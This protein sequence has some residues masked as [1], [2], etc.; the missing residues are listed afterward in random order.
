PPRHVRAVIAIHAVGADDDVLQDL[1]ERRA[2]MD[3]PVGV[4]RPVMQDPDRPV[5]GPPQLLEALVQLP[6]FPAPQELRFPLAQLG[7]HGELGARQ[8]QRLLVVHVLVRVHTTTP[9]EHVRRS[10]PAVTT[11]VKKRPAPRRDGQ[12]SRGTTLIER[13][14]PRGLASHSCADNGGSRPSLLALRLSMGSSGVIFSGRR[15]AGLPPTPARLG[16]RPRLLSPSSPVGAC[17]S[18]GPNA[19]Q[20]S[21]GS[22]APAASPATAASAGIAGSLSRPGAA[23]RCA[24]M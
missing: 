4:G 22:P 17:C 9:P 7:A 5:L 1:V 14:A 20:L 24:M 8:L 12:S 19:R 15:T 3:V 6:F 11:G 16:L 21:F 18:H 10:P 13:K 2:D 23:V